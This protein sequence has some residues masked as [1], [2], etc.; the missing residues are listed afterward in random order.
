MRNR[1]PAA[2]GGLNPLDA[3]PHLE[4]VAPLPDRHSSRSPRRSRAPGTHRG[5]GP[6]SRR[7]APNVALG[8]LAGLVE[9]RSRATAAV[10]R[11]LAGARRDH[12]EA[13]QLLHRTVVDRV[14]H[15]L[16]HVAF[17]LDRAPREVAARG[18]LADSSA[19]QLGDDDPGGQG[20][21]GERSLVEG[22]H[23]ALQRR[24][25]AHAVAPT[26]AAAPTAPPPSRDASPG[27]GRGRQSGTE[28]RSEARRRSRAPPARSQPG[29]PRPRWL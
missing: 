14:G 17:G 4:A 28:R 29:R 21:G 3:E 11:R 9:Q 1:S 26:S 19:S 18:R 20:A 5:R 27:S 24:V 12:V 6:R 15:A 23:V 13:N 10:R 25:A 7:A 8:E 2:S 16:S 22:E